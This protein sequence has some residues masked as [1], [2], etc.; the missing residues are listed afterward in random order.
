MNKWAGYIKYLHDW[1][2]EHQSEDCAGMAPVCYNEWLDNESAVTFSDVMYANNLTPTDLDFGYFD[3]RL[4]IVTYDSNVA[5]NNVHEFV[6]WLDNL[7]DTFSGYVVFS[8]EV[9][10]RYKDG[11]WC[12]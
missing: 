12:V 1:A 5:S 4:T 7:D 11:R 6:S 10:L 3:S 9:R 2:N 8:N